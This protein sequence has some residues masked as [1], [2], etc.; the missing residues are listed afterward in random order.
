MPLPPSRNGR[1]EP[2]TSL[3][4]VQ[5]VRSGS[6]ARYTPSFR[7]PTNTVAGDA[8]VIRASQTTLPASAST[9]T[10]VSPWSLLRNS[11]LSEAAKRVRLF[12][13][14]TTILRTNVLRRASSDVPTAVQLAP[15][16]RERKMPWSVP[17]MRR[18][19]EGSVV[20]MTARPEAFR[21]GKEASPRGI[22]VV[23]PSVERQTPPPAAVAK[24][25]ALMLL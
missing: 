9:A 4:S 2:G 1:A 22:H 19:S 17:R 21:V 5:L 18:G 12:L 11:P 3:R 23:P 10:Q 24:R 16:L 13:G 15:P 6:R 7:T 20:G 8:L 14:C 25:W